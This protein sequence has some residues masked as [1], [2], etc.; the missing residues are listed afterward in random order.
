MNLGAVLA[1]EGDAA[2]AT[3]L[4]EAMVIFDRLGDQPGRARTLHDLGFVAA[5]QGNHAL[6]RA[7]F[8]ASLALF[9]QLHD[10]RNGAKCLEGLAGVAVAS[11]QDERAARLF[12][13]A[14][15][16]REAI[17]AP[18]PPSYCVSYEENVGSVRASLA[19]APLVAAWA[20]GRA[21]SLEEAVAYALRGA[22]ETA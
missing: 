9:H 21:M 4:A 22:T 5:R 19:A 11:G 12:G 7:R 14:E 8:A 13:A 20:E 16:L 18:L 3:L 6:A 10:R 17:G 2:A 15:A 1:F